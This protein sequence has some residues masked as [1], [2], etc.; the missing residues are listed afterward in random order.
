MSSES[1]KDAILDIVTVGGRTREEHDENVDALLKSLKRYGWTS[2]EAK[3]IEPMPEINI[4]GYC[5]GNENIKPDP[6]RLRPLLNMPTPQD[7]TSL[8]RLL[9][10]FAY[11]AIWVMNFSDKIANLNS[12]KKFP[13]TSKALEELGLLK[14]EIAK[15][16]LQSIDENLPFVV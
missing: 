1:L 13:L 11:Y 15:A 12:T 3:I 10:M 2:N 7:V 6:E 16:S 8:K 5:E 4:L 9:G 14:E